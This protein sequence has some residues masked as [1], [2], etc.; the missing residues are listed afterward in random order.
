MDP[1]C[2]VLRESEPGAFGAV[3]ARTGEK[4]NNKIKWK[5]TKLKISLTHEGNGGSGVL[6]CA[7]FGTLVQSR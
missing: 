2:E 7:E 5:R 6:L 3:G 4:Y 1:D